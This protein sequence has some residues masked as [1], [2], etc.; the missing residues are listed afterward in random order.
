MDLKTKLSRLRTKEDLVLYKWACGK[1]RIADMFI[2]LS[3]L[4]LNVLTC[5]GGRIYFSSAAPILYLERGRSVIKFVDKGVLTVVEGARKGINVLSGFLHE[6][7]T[8]IPAQYCARREI[9]G[10]PP[11]WIEQKIMSL[12]CSPCYP[13]V[14]VIVPE[15]FRITRNLDSIRPLFTSAMLAAIGATRSDSIDRLLDLFKEH[16]D[17]FGTVTEAG[18][19]LPN[20]F[21]AVG[22]L[23]V[24]SSKG[25]CMKSGSAVHSIPLTLFKE[26]ME[27]RKWSIYT[28]EPNELERTD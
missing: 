2:P 7:E 25:I 26:S 19:V 24:A 13:M 21:V 5:N 9:D 27:A 10:T 4:R 16:F 15:L 22:G 12:G 18:Y 8:A 11:K 23:C 14:T 3:N 6:D 1:S 20:E 28:G 17:L